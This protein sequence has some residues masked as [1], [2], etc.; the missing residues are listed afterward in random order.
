M[1]SGITSTELLDLAALEAIEPSIGDRIDVGFA[2]LMALVYNRTRDKSERAKKPHDF[3][4]RWG[5]TDHDELERTLRSGIDRLREARK[6]G[7]TRTL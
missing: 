1:A 7:S 2:Q 4:P 5:P 3:M 6:H